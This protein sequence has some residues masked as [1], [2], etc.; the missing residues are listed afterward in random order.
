MSFPHRRLPIFSKQLLR[1]YLGQVATGCY[2]GSNN[3][4]ATSNFRMSRS[5]HIARQTLTEAALV[6]PNWG[7]TT[8]ASNA[9]AKD[10]TEFNGGAITLTASIEYPANT[11]TQV[12]WGGATSKTDAGGGTVVSDMM[13]LT[14]PIPEGALFW[15]RIYATCAAGQILI[16]TAN[17][18]GGDWNPT[19]GLNGAGMEAAA[20][21]GVDKTMGG[22][23]AAH[24]VGYHYSPAA[25]IA[26]TRKPSVFII[27]DSKAYGLRD[28]LD[29][30][31]DTGEIAR[32]VGPYL[33]YINNGICSQKA[34]QFA[35]SNTKQKALAAYCSDVICQ[36]G[37]N[38]YHLDNIAP[39]SL[40]TAYQ[41]I[42]NLFPG[43]RVW[44]A[45]LH[46]ESAST[47]N[48]ATV[49][50][51][52]TAAYAPNLQATNA[53]IKTKPSQ[54]AGYF[55]VDAAVSS[56]QGSNKWAVTGAANGYTADGLHQNQAGYRLASSAITPASFLR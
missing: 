33:A 29:A 27:G 24:G 30:S 14:T 23:V 3:F 15:V 49:A 4:S 48:F 56:A 34:T 10:G 26:T 2:S 36:L 46:A 20:S 1:P 18:A 42:W 32:A 12:K 5:P 16:F 11:F 38:D 37:I 28:T 9:G 55:D 21:G 41:T 43:K 31:G 19:T 45:T 35:A 52:T 40:Q 54:L 50:N 22:T 39:A 8:G 51:Q 53:Y 7:V 17:T 13:T 44:Q 47:D 6:I 25:I